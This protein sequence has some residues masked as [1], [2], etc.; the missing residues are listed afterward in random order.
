[1]GSDEKLMPGYPQASLVKSAWLSDGLST[2]GGILVG[3]V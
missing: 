2:D 1:M 3:A